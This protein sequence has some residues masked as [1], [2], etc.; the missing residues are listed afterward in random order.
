MVTI[1]DARRLLIC[2]IVLGLHISVAILGYGVLFIY[3]L[4]MF[5]STYN[6]YYLEDRVW[7]MQLVLSVLFPN[8]AFGLSAIL[9]G[10]IRERKWALVTWATISATVSSFSFVSVIIFIVEFHHFSP[11]DALNVAI[12]VVS[13]GLSYYAYRL[14]NRQQDIRSLDVEIPTL[15]PA[16]KA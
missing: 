2:K 14:I 11:V 13:G 4:Y 15:R 10:L 7:V 16:Y 3:I 1:S 6:S 9:Y 5:F 12:H 8:L